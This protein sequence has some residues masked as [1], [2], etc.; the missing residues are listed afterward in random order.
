MRLLILDTSDA[1][2]V[3]PKNL[4]LKDSALDNVKYL[5]S[6]NGKTA[7]ICTPF[8]SA[9]LQ[10]ALSWAVKQFNPLGLINFGPLHSF[11]KKD[12]DVLIPDRTL[13]VHGLTELHGLSL[14][15]EDYVFDA[16]IQAELLAQSP[17]REL[18]TDL[19][20][21][22]P[23]TPMPVEADWL[24]SNSGCKNYAISVHEL[25]RYAQDLAIPIGCVRVGSIGRSWL[26]SILQLA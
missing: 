25:Q 6:E 13:G 12:D 15:V 17:S 9:T 1:E 26:A 7:L 23:R 2:A 21:S 5:A 22:L 24:Q 19:L 20:L 4:D 14:L 8:E 18:R 3:L 11:A 16:T 10:S